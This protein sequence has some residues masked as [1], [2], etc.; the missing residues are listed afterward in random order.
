MGLIYLYV[1]LNN[2]AYYLVIHSARSS[3]SSINGW[4]VWR[5]KENG[6]TN[7]SSESALSS[8]DRLASG[9]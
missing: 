6:L 5:L 7:Y 1:L 8:T 3:F 9:L 4:G 2:T